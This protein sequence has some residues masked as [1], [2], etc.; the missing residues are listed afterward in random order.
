MTG[1]VSVIY[2]MDR[3]YGVKED[4]AVWEFNP[5]SVHWSEYAGGPVRS[6]PPVRVMAAVPWRDRIFVFG[7]LGEV[8]DFTPGYY[9]ADAP[10]WRYLGEARA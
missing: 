8:W 9:R 7:D 5:E 1:F 2:H 6:G 10:T 4:G 3:I